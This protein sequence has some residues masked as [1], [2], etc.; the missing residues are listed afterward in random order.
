MSFPSFL[1][2]S[3]KSNF[4]HLD[5]AWRNQVF[6]YRAI[7]NSSCITNHLSNN[8]RRI[9]HHLLTHTETQRG[10]I[11]QFHRL[12]GHW[13]ISL[14][15]EKVTIL[16]AGLRLRQIWQVGAPSYHYNTTGISLL[17]LSHL[18]MILLLLFTYLTFPQI[19]TTFSF[20]L[21]HLYNIKYTRFY[22][23]F[24]FDL[25]PYLPISMNF[26]RMVPDSMELSI[27]LHI[28]MEGV[29]HWNVEDSSGVFTRLS[30]L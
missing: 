19:L 11:L 21:I 30:D 8:Y 13:S 17:N 23:L 2:V 4:N 1:G 16:W 5:Y 20:S 6:Q 29:C 27:I 10:E 24:V 7:C 9:L 15:G 22:I 28:D 14:C 25:Q 18:I 26:S 12:F 3:I